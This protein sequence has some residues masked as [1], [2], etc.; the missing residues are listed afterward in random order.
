MKNLSKFVKEQMQ[1][2]A[3][4]AEYEEA[5]AEMHQIQ[6][7]IEKGISKEDSEPSSVDTKK[8]NE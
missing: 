4:A 2:A 6:A 1:D 5:K 3:F 8:S 7:H